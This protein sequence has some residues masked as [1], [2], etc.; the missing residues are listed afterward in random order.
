M[1]AETDMEA[2]ANSSGRGL[3]IALWIAVLA[4]IAGFV[5]I[6]SAMSLEPLYAG[7]LLL[8]YWASIDKADFKA[9]PKTTLGSFAGLALAWSLRVLPQELGGAGLA[10]ALLVVALAILIQILNIAPF[11][12][13]APF[14]LYLTVFAAPV[15]QREESFSAVAV[16]IAAGTIY[17]ACFVW[18]PIAA[19]RRLIDRG[20]S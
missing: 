1:N 20:N 14:M 3:G 9:L 17:F 4:A 12:V 6:G 18:G 7:F 2:E 8:W 15:L 13:N 5:A 19:K 10:I 16:S 11:I